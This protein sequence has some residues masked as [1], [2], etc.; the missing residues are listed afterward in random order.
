M[1]YGNVQLLNWLLHE[2]VT[3]STPN[4]ENLCNCYGA[5]Y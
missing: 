2:N 5:T 1:S 4:T 3:L